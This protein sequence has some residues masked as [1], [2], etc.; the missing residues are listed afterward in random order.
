META[1]VPL[2]FP[3]CSP[4]DSAAITVISLG[5]GRVL[6]SASAARIARDR[7]PPF[8]RTRPTR[9]RVARETIRQLAARASAPT[10]ENYSRLYAEISGRA[11]IP[12]GGAGPRASAAEA[13]KAAGLAT[14][15]QPAGQAVV[16]RWDEVAACSA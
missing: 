12:S 5:S 8:S 4:L 6:A 2:S 10:P 11:Q 9:P 16:E 7:C 13:G 15:A 3:A 14:L 1:K